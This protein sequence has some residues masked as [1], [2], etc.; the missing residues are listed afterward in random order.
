M[1]NYSLNL[2]S[3]L[4]TDT[5][6]IPSW[7]LTRLWPDWKRTI[8]D[9]GG[10]WQ[11]SASFRA[12]TSPNRLLDFFVTAPFRRVV[13]TLGGSDTWEGFISEMTYTSPRGLV[14]SWSVLDMVN[15]ARTIYSFIGDNLFSDGDAES[16]T[17]TQVGTPSTFEFTE[18]WF[19]KGT[20]SCHVVTDDVD[21]GLRIDGATVAIV[22]ST[23]YQ[24]SVSTNIVSGTWTIKVHRNDNDE[25]IAERVSTATGNE[26]LRTQLPVTNEYAGAVYVQ[27]TADAAAREIFADAATFQIAPDR[28]ET[29][30]QTD[31]I[32]SGEFGRIEEVFLKGG[33]TD[34]AANSLSSNIVQDWAWPQVIPPQRFA[35][36]RTTDR[37]PAGLSVVLSG[38]VHTLAWKNAVST[39]GTDQAS[40]HIGNLINESEFVT[41]GYIQA[42]TMNAL[43]PEDE[44]VTLWDATEEII[45]SGDDSSNVSWMG[46]VYPGRIFEY[47]KRPSTVANQFD[48]GRLLSVHGGFFPP[49][50]ARPNLIR[51]PAMPILSPGVTGRIQDDPKVIWAKTVGFQAPN[52][53]WIER[54]KD[55]WE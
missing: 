53:A 48:R 45:K 19:R 7:D 32:S 5:S 50:Y 21:E 46:G 22:A 37:R 42:N 8:R 6:F 27:I 18:D 26:V 1:A 29:G 24:I 20:Q 30:W 40:D 2:Y 34:A 25:V 47:Q 23:A 55:T 54:D 51:L 4:A 13:E 39:G 52:S 11:G 10:C 44:S 36:F 38:Y 33:M 14:F 43:V 12:G 16:S 31:T 35:T 28:R 15:Y 9:V 17:W 3:N 41:P 49:R